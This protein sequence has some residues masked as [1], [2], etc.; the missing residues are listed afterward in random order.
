MLVLLLLTVATSLR[1]AAGLECPLTPKNVS[2]SDQMP[3]LD[4]DP[5]DCIVEY[6]LRN[7]SECA[8]LDLRG[9]SW[10]RRLGAVRMR[11]YV[12]T[13]D[14]GTPVTAFNVSFLDV[15]WSREYAKAPR[16][17]AYTRRPSLCALTELFTE[18]HEG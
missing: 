3:H 10:A 12:W 14:E 4:L 13:D 6:Y 15:R 2:C 7:S 1:A 8:A 9:E 17:A 18:Q 11:P 16:R 5:E